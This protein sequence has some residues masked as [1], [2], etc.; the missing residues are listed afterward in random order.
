MRFS[1][2]QVKMGVLSLSDTIIDT[3]LYICGLLL[4]ATLFCDG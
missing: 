4:M 2:A 3:M 1:S